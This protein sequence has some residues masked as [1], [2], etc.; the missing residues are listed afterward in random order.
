MKKEAPPKHI[1]IVTPDAETR[2]DFIK[3]LARTVAGLKA[4]DRF[5]DLL[6]DS[7]ENADEEQIYPRV[8][9]IFGEVSKMIFETYQSPNQ[10]RADIN[11][12]LSTF[13]AMQREKAR[14]N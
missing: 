6:A 8:V 10:L 4:L 12:L 7:D 5:A 1:I 3:L 14:D 13:Y 9:T 11:S 2:S